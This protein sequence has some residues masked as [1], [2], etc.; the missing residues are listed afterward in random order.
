VV[1]TGGP[2][3][4]YRQ[5]AAILRARIV[6]GDLAPDAPLPSE[7]ALCQEYGI[8]RD[9]VRKAVRLLRDEGLVV[10]VQGK[11]SYAAR[12]GPAAGRKPRGH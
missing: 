1:I 11:G 5:L 12:K 9:S 2:E 6:S 3:P 4:V 7:T 10:T 8:S